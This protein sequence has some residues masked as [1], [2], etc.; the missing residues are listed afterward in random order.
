M[1]PAYARACFS[2]SAVV[3]YV[4]KTKGLRV[5]ANDRLRY[6]YHIAR[7]IIENNSVTVS[8]EELD[9]LLKDNPKG[10][11]FKQET[12]HCVFFTKRIKLK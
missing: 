5:F 1:P 4:Y 10:G 6:C 12:F 9:A 7:A 2:G 8:E 11:R 3:G